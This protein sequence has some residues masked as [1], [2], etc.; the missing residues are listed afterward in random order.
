MSGKDFGLKSINI[1]LSITPA[2]PR[3]AEASAEEQYRDYSTTL[4][5]GLCLV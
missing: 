2:F 4:N 3:A 5:I 1:S